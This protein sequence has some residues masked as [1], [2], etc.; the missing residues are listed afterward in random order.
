MQYGEAMAYLQQLTKF[1]INLGLGRIEE[2]LGRLGNPHRQLRVIHV[3]GTNGKGSTSVMVSSILQAAGYRAGLFTS[4]HLH[5]YTERYRING[6]QI[7]L[8]R[9]TDLICRLRPHLEAMVAEGFEHP[10]EFEVS[11]AMAFEIGRA[12]V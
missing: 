7:Q 8:G 6:E 12:H 3:G 1:G 9:V 4:P 10:T 11:T 2:L 5:S